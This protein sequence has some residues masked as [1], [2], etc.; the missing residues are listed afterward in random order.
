MRTVDP[1]AEQPKR[2][3]AAVQVPAEPTASSSSGMFEPIRGLDP[4]FGLR[5]PP[6]KKSTPWSAWLQR[7]KP[8]T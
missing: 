7:R 8:R 3:K 4:D 5:L 1:A 6:V 2:R